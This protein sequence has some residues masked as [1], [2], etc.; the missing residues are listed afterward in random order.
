MTFAVVC[1][2]TVQAEPLYTCVEAMG[3]PM[4]TNVTL[5]L[6]SS[7]SK[8]SEQDL[9]TRA[10]EKNILESLRGLAPM[11]SYVDPLT[12]SSSIP[13]SYMTN[14]ARQRRPSLRYRV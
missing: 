6:K 13:P 3:G 7:L 8:K 14:S 4:H 1:C 10:S 9:P 2:K 12:A 11:V 5:S